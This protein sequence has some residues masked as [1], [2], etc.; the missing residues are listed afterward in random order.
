VAG[1]RATGRGV[2]VTLAY[3]PQTMKNFEKSKEKKKKHS[4]HSILNL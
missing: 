2:K 1:D 3:F 4:G